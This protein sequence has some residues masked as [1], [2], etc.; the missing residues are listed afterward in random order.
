MIN[1]NSN[2]KDSITTSKP[3]LLKI[4]SQKPTTK[5][6]T[7]SSE[8]INQTKSDSIKTSLPN[9]KWVVTH[10][11]KKDYQELTTEVVRIDFREISKMSVEQLKPIRD[12]LEKIEIK[13]TDHYVR[14]RLKEYVNKQSRDKKYIELTEEEYDWL[15]TVDIK[16]YCI[17]NDAKLI[18][19]GWNS[20]GLICKVAYVLRIPDSV[21]KEKKDRYGFFCFGMDGGLKTAYLTPYFKFRSS[22]KGCVYKKLEELSD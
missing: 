5:A 21:Y 4:H 9:I 8:L 3:S 10:I 11:N 22:Y 14:E 16:Q 2:L 20:S 18:E 1:Q 6:I 12:W 17:N 15:L 13:K 7:K 19:I